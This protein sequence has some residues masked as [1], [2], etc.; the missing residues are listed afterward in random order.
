MRSTHAL[1]VGEVMHRRLRPVD[2]RLRYRVFMLLVDLDDLVEL[3]RRLRL[4]SIGKFNLFGLDLRDYGD[5]QAAGPRT[6]VDSL[7]S[8]AGLPTGGPVR[9]LTMPR[10]LGYTFNP[11]NVY[12]CGHP[13]GG[14][15]AILYEVNNTFGERHAYLLPV[16]RPGSANTPIRQRIDKAMH[17]SPFLGM[18]HE[19]RFRIEPPG[20][21]APAMSLRVDV[22]DAEGPL[23]LA[24]FRGTRMQLT[25]RALLFRFLALPLMTLKVMAGIHWE[26]LRLWAKGVPIH[27]HP[28]VSGRAQ[29]P[30]PGRAT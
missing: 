27:P 14:L 4:L 16:E 1:Y 28:R 20:E 25:D 6:H 7:L 29:R 22:H 11:L 8:R 17:V 9:L 26:A 13:D 19:Y 2:H 18:D 10:V 30:D 15:Q 23:L 5:G 3:G 12:F 21:H 24:S